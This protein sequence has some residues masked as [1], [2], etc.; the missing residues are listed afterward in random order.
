MSIGNR[1]LVSFSLPFV[2][3]HHNYSYFVSLLCVARAVFSLPPYIYYYKLIIQSIFCEE[4]IWFFD[5]NAFKRAVDELM[6]VT[7]WKQFY[8]FQFQRK[9]YSIWIENH[10]AYELIVACGSVTFTLR[11]NFLDCRY[12][13]WYILGNSC[14]S[15][16]VGRHCVRI[17]TSYILVQVESNESLNEGV[18]TR[19]EET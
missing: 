10:T 1:C 19:S 8:F 17:F 14:L 16:W 3:M 13:L 6:E 2:P 5:K 12:I 11:S 18:V 4:L 9:S 7:G 15:Q